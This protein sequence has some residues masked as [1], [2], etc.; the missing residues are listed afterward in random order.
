MKRWRTEAA[1]LQ[2]MHARHAEWGVIMPWL[3][4]ADPL[5]YF[6]WTLRYDAD[7]VERT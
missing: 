5:E 1:V 6:E 4:R 2:G 7:V 3:L